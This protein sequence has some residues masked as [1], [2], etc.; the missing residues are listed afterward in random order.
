MT[1]CLTTGAV[2]VYIYVDEQMETNELQ[3]CRLKG[4]FNI[5]FEFYNVNCE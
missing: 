5:I 2:N 1:V 3:C 4:G